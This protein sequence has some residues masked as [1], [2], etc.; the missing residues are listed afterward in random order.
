MSAQAFPPSV[1]IKQMSSVKRGGSSSLW[2]PI[3]GEDNCILCCQ[4]QVMG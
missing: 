1:L 2:D 3:A 4:G